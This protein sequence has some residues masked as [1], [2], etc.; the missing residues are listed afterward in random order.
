MP[1]VPVGGSYNNAMRT[2]DRARTTW[3]VRDSGKGGWVH[4][5]EASWSWS[6]RGNQL[7]TENEVTRV[8]AGGSSLGYDEF[9]QWS[10]RENNSL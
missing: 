8:G 4:A 2:V 3:G 6:R 5:L 9:I 7:E 1:G 10:S